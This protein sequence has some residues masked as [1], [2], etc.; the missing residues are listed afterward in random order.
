MF[1]NKKKEHKIPPALQH[2]KSVALVVSYLKH[3]PSKMTSKVRSPF[4]SQNLTTR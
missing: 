2:K 3:A 1:V 4:W